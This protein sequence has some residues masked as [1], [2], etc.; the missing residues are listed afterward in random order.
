MKKA[1]I[2]G[3]CGQDGSYLAEHLLSL[4]SYEVHGITRGFTSGFGNYVRGVTYHIGDMRDEVSLENAFRKVWPDEVYNFAAQTF[5]PTSWSLPEETF[6]VN[7][8]GLTRLLKIV[9][10][11]KKDTKVYQAGSSEQFGNVG[12]SLEEYSPMKPVSPYGISKTAAHKMVEVYRGTGLYVVGGILFNHESPRRTENMVTRKITRHVAKWA[13]GDKDVL[14]LGN[15][16]AARDWAHAKDMVRGIWMMM[17]QEKADDYVLGTGQTHTVLNF[18]QQSVKA[19]GLRWGDVKHLVRGN[20]K[21][22]VRKGELH[23]LRADAS[24]AKIVLGWEPEVTFDE[25][26]KDM[27]MSDIELEQRKLQIQVAPREFRKLIEKG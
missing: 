8:G 6:D 12:G 7:V 23:Y 1:L 10:R 20:Q 17:Q 25:L 5:V 24:K 19:A 4:G 21:A 3:I 9:E 27:V 13:L 14:E 22:F 18:L 11:L 16:Q 2:T 15:L 26:V